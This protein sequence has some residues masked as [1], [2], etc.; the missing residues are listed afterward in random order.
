MSKLLKNNDNIVVCLILFLVFLLSLSKGPIFFPDSGS[1]E[2]HSILRMGLYPLTITF[3]KFFLKIQAF[4]YLA[5]FQTIFSL[6]S[7]YYLSNFLFRLFKLHFYLYL[8]IICIFLFPLVSHSS[9]CNILSESIAYPLFLLT[10]L[11]FFKIVSYK[12]SR[13]N[14]IFAILIFL[15]CFTRQQFMFF[16]V[17]AFLYSFYTLVFEKNWKHSKQV[18]IATALSFCTF[19]IAERSYHSVYHDHFAGTPFGGTLF[20][21]RP[22]F[23]ASEKALS[24]IDEPKQ[25]LFL[26]EV[27]EELKQ[28]EIIEPGAPAKELFAFEYFFNTMLWKVSWKTGHK[29]WAK[30]VLDKEFHKNHTDFEVTQ[31]IDHN[32]MTIGLKLIKVNF[33]ASV[34]YYIKDVFRG[35]GG[36]ACT[37]LIFMLSL[38]CIMAAYNSKKVNLLYFLTIS[39]IVMHFGNSAFVCLF[40]PPLTR[41]TYSTNALFLVMIAILLSKLFPYLLMQN[42]ELCAE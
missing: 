41:Y 42:K 30:D 18:L 27:V 1:Y 13:D 5:I 22:L 37:F 6:L 3:F 11:F 33:I 26:S 29:I 4:K 39:S 24:S 2:S 17:V 16:Y 12:K 8:T 40:N 36:Y 15:L 28:K 19:F 7:V 9:A 31:I 14:I 34:I 23:V 10:S 38:A 20:L 32:M 25:K 21:I 35:I